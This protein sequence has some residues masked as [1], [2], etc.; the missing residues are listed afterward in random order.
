MVC[1]GRCEAERKLE[2]GISMLRCAR[3]ATDL[4]D[5]GDGEGV[6]GRLAAG[7]DDGD[8]WPRHG[9]IEECCG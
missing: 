6:L 5:I 8:G 1:G 2:G 4:E 7:G 9:V 3:E